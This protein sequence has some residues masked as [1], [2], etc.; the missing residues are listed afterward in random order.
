MADVGGGAEAEH[1]DVVERDA[2]RSRGLDEGD[3]GR[4]V[5]PQ[6]AVDQPRPVQRMSGEIRRRGRGGEGDVDGLLPPVPLQRRQVRGPEQVNVVGGHVVAGDHQPLGALAEG[7]L[8]EDAGERLLERLASVLGPEKSPQ[9]ARPGAVPEDPRAVLGVE[10]RYLPG[11]QAQPEAQGDDPARR[12][13]GDQIE[14]VGDLGPEILLQA[15]EDRRREH[16]PE[17]TTVQGQDLEASCHIRTPGRVAATSAPTRAD[18]TPLT[19]VLN[20]TSLFSACW[21]TMKVYGFL[22]VPSRRS[23]AL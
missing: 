9:G 4:V 15:R 1:P 2:E 22:R 21:S 20:I 23:T 3:H 8:T 16:P 19:T 11:R 6:A 18:Q 10:G 17:T 12:G 5:G 13:P 14:V 7:P